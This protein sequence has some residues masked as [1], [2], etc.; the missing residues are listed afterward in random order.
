MEKVCG[1]HTQDEM[2]SC[3]VARLTRESGRIL[4]DRCKPFLSEL[5]TAVI[6]CRAYER[7]TLNRTAEAVRE[8]TTGRRI[9]SRERIR[10]I[11]V[12]SLNR[13]HRRIPSIETP[14]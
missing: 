8:L 1:Y 9:L 13:L 2:T 4:L 6:V 10:Q 12:I 5:E 7:L 3:V 14:V 11:Y